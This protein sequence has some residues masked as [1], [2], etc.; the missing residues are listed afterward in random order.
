MILLSIILFS[1]WWLFKKCSDDWKTVVI[2]SLIGA[3]GIPLA[4]IGL[5]YIAAA[6]FAASPFFLIQPLIPHG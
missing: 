5:I 1:A 4:A 2:G 3:S 6:Q